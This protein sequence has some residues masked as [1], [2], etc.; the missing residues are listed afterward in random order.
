MASGQNPQKKIKDPLATN[1]IQVL[2]L[3]RWLR[4]NLIWGKLFI[5]PKVLSFCARCSAK[6]IINLCKNWVLSQKTSQSLGKRKDTRQLL[7][8]DRIKSCTLT[9]QL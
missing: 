2:G 4:N 1:N 9:S 6:G 5:H 3:P 8:N 7:I